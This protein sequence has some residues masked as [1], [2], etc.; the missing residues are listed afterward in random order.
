MDN[1]VKKHLLDTVAHDLFLVKS[2]IDNIE[3]KY[4]KH[5]IA[6]QLYLAI[7]T[8]FVY[9]TEYDALKDKLKGLDI[10]ICYLCGLCKKRHIFVPNYIIKNIVVLKEWNYNASYN[11]TWTI[12]INTLKIT[13]Q[14]VEKWYNDIKN[15]IEL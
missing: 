10:D 14:E 3:N 2:S 8:L 11:A 5:T 7:E 1:K 12:R 15:G 9:L 13:L 6:K 4:T